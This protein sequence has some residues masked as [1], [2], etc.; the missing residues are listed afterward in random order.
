MRPKGAA[1]RIGVPFPVRTQRVATPS[2]RGAGEQRLLDLS[3]ISI[4]YI[5][6]IP[7]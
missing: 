2:G 6:S 1:V 5:Y 7:D 3:F 4:P